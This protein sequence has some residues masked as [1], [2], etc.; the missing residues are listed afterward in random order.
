MKYY[1][2]CDYNQIYKQ[3]EH[4]PGDVV[5]SIRIKSE[6]RLVS[7]LADGL[8]S[9]VKANVLATLTTTM[10]AKFVAGDMDICQAARVIMETLPICSQRQI[11]YST[12]TII[13]IDSD[14]FTKVIEHDNPEYLLL[15]N[16]KVQKIDKQ[17]IALE[18]IHNRTAKLLFS[19]FQLEPEDRIVF[20]SDG[21]TQS[22]IGKNLTP[23][24]WGDAA[25]KDFVSQTVQYRQDISARE[26]SRLVVEQAF[27]IDQRHA[28]DD[29]TCAVIYFRNPRRTL[30]VTGPPYD[31]RKDSELA[32]MV[33][34]FEGKKIIA[35]GTTANI[36]SRE[37]NLPIDVNLGD[38]DACKDLPPSA[39]LEGIDLITEGTITLSYVA[40]L[41]E[42]DNPSN[43]RGNTAVSKLADMLLNSDIID[44]VVGTRINEAHQD[45]NLPQ[46]LEIR[47]NLM[48]KLCTHLETKYMKETHLQFL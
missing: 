10:A 40:Q 47:R 25:L 36:I 27:E 33:A 38:L 18:E 4:V 41:L 16:G 21:I 11:G 12:F 37:L 13:D 28:C 35:G 2:E 1:I 23:L 7:V 5:H 9:G 39:N 42:A 31:K 29:I 43:H 15:R 45:P 32:A 24:G 26:L 22:G 30:L 8:G 48:K 14:G 34:G 17:I 6:N 46:E 19:S 20:C 3:G 44:F